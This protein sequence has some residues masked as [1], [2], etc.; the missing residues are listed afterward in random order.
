MDW[1]LEFKFFYFPVSREFSSSVNFL[2]SNRG[3][4]RMEYNYK[5]WGLRRR[6][7]TSSLTFRRCLLFAILKP[8]A[9]VPWAISI[10]DR[11]VGHGLERHPRLR[12]R[13]R[14]G[15]LGPRYL[16]PGARRRRRQRWRHRPPPSAWLGTNLSLSSF[17]DRFKLDY[18]TES[19]NFAKTTLQI[20]SFLDV[21]FLDTL[22]K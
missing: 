12:V 11:S 20:A 7:M 13:H 4:V 18:V 1:I 21:S 22:R 5:R 17:L 8:L 6:R 19:S 9:D 10:D 2:Y 3:L 16:R 15:A 14:A